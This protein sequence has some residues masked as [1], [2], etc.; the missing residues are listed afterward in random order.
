M[1]TARQKLVAQEIALCKSDGVT[2]K[3]TIAQRLFEKY[4]ELFP[5]KDAARSS[6]RRM[7]GSKCRQVPENQKDIYDNYAA[8]SCKEYDMAKVRPTV[9][10][11]HYIVTSAV[12]GTPVF[13]A[14]WTNLTS[15]AAFLKAEIYVIAMRYRN[16]TSVF[17]DKQEETWC[18]DVIP[19][20]D[21]NRHVIHKSVEVM[22]DIKIQPTSKNPLNGKESISGS[23]SCIIG[24]PRVHLKFLPVLKGQKPKMMLTTGSV[25]LPNY[26]D[27]GIG[28]EGEF[29]HTYGFSIVSIVD[30]DLADIRY[31]TA[32]SD[33]GFI[34]L[35]VEVKDGIISKAGNAKALIL[36]D[37][38]AAKLTEQ[39][40]LRIEQ[41]AKK[42]SPEVIVL[43][44][45]F[46]G[47]S[48]NPHE[49]LN[50]I[51][52]HRKFTLGKHILADEIDEAISV[53]DHINKLAPLTVIVNSNHDRFLDRYISTTN[54]KLDIANAI[55][56][57][58]LALKVLC[59]D[60]PK[61]IFAKI[62]EER[63]PDVKYLGIDESFMIM[64]IE[65]GN[66]GDIGSN[67]SKGSPT[68]FRKLSSKGV[69]GHTHSPLRMD[70]HS[71]VGCQDRYHGYNIGASSWAL[72]D[73]IINAD[74]KR[75]HVL[76][77]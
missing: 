59:G 3:H 76:Y 20:L 39:A 31:V 15:Y 1:I 67:G 16:P 19:Y 64:D 69:T 32:R 72:G 33:G 12:N 61:G 57:A 21:A 58:G 66:H 17:T 63:I 70:G 38:H 24:H 26:T 62:V 9:Q 46:D 2:K 29:H 14:F 6:V 49:V 40:M 4:P 68:Q 7:L 45:V 18:A 11:K 13:K 22:G 43:H 54:W 73:V 55:T 52:L 71:V 30:D 28:A 42:Y 47:E 74:G 23:M 27:S 50:P 60:A 77:F 41:T 75:Q 51:E 34:D 37:I 25:T 44:D 65:L 53:I 10:A 36:G 8:G 48:I 5:S 56:Y 35:S